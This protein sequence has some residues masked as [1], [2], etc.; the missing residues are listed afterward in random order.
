MAYPPNRRSQCPS[1]STPPP[2]AAP[3]SDP[4]SPTP[5]SCPASPPP[6]AS[7]A[8][9]PTLP[10]LA[11]AR[12]AST[13]PR[14]PS[15]ISAL[16]SSLTKSRHAGVVS[17]GR[18]ASAS[19]RTRAARGSVRIA[20]RL[21]VAARRI[22]ALEQ[23]AACR[24][25]D[26]PPRSPPTPRRRAPDR[27]PAE[28]RRRSAYK[29]SSSTARPLR[30]RCRSNRPRRRENPAATSRHVSA[31]RLQ[32]RIAMRRRIGSKLGRQAASA[33]PASE[34]SETRASVPNAATTRRAPASSKPLPRQAFGRRLIEQRDQ[35]PRQLE[36][37]A[38]AS[39]RPTRAALRSRDQRWTSF[40]SKNSRLSG[41]I[42][43]ANVANAL[44]RQIVAAYR[45]ADC[46]A[47]SKSP[48]ARIR[49]NT[50]TARALTRTKA[51]LSVR[52]AR[53]VGS[54]I[55]TRDRTNGSCASENRASTPRANSSAKAAPA[56]IVNRLIRRIP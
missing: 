50:V 6:R 10:R 21:D 49:G 30:A 23:V 52:I 54:K 20:P 45:R 37:Q 13:S 5:R 31:A 2:H 44:R 11:C 22:H 8:R 35:L 40:V 26:A 51:S 48:S 29:R 15:A 55:R 41:N 25:A 33:I 4:A 46:G 16:C 36:R 47:S 56:G 39:S 42:G 9:W 14:K 43:G 3:A 18:K 34:S 32:R 12:P 38:P 7:Q 1:A 28:R 53:R 17:A 24:A 19:N 27:Y